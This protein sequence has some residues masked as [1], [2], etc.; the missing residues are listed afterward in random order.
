MVGRRCNVLEMLRRLRLGESVRGAEPL[1]DNRVG[2][3]FSGSR[4]VNLPEALPNLPRRQ[5]GAYC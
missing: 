3:A 2:R 4:W 5:A 1:P